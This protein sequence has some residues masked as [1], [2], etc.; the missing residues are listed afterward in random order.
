[1]CYALLRCCIPFNFGG[2]ILYFEALPLSSDRCRFASPLRLVWK[3]HRAAAL[4]FFSFE[5]ARNLLRFRLPCQPPS[6][7]PSFPPIRLC[8]LRDFAVSRGGGFYHRRVRCQLRS[9]TSYFVFQTRSGAPVAVATSL[10]RS[11]G[12]ASTTTAL[13]VNRL[14][15]PLL[16]APSTP[17][18]VRLRRFEGRGFYHRRVGSQH[19]PVDSVFRLSASSRSS[20]RQCGFAFL[21]TGGDGSTARSF[22]PSTREPAAPLR[23]PVGRREPIPNALLPGR[24]I[25]NRDG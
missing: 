16:P 19:R 15:R 23:Q 21:S 24:Q 13:R 3:Q 7:T 5:G 17:S 18:P 4:C 14:R 6:S 20:H 12:A 9:L 1:M 2:G 11:G 10:S 8:R 22:Q 25:L